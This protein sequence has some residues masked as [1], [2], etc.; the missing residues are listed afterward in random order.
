MYIGLQH[1]HSF[2]AYL[3]LAGILAAL[4]AAAH[5][6][7]TGRARGK[8]DRL[9]ALA[10]MILAHLQLVL[11]IVLYMV[12]PLGLSNFSAEAMGDA[13]TRL[14]LVEHPFAMI[15]GI[16]LVTVGYSVAKRKESDGAAAKWIL[17]GYASGLL[18]ILSRIPWHAWF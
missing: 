16:V 14:Y 10:G 4:A 7:A 5:L 6:L 12:S 2:T 18:L 3:T 17:G 13:I 11:G 9:T 1:L 15:V 8:A